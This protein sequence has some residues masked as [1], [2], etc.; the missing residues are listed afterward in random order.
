MRSL[1]HGSRRR[2]VL[3]VVSNTAQSQIMGLIA[4]QLTDC[5]LLAVNTTWWEYSRVSIEA[6][7]ERQ[8][9]PFRSLK[10]LSTD[11]VEKVLSEERPDIVVVGHDGVPGH[12]EFIDT[13]AGAGLP[14]L[15]IQDGILTKNTAQ[16]LKRP[17]PLGILRN[18]VVL[19][20]RFPA[21][22]ASERFSLRE[23]AA[24]TLYDLQHRLTRGEAVYG[25]GKTTKMAVFGR[26]TREILTA[27]G[28]HPSRIVVTGNPKFDRLHQV[29]RE[30]HG[31][32]IRERWGIPA[33]QALV[34]LLTQYFVESHIWTPEQR[35]EFVRSIAE[36]VASIPDTRLI[37]KIRHPR[38]S[39][40]EYR[41]IVTDMPNPP[42]VWGDAP[43]PELLSSVHLAIGVSS[44]AL[45][46]AMALERPVVIVDLREY[47]TG[48]SYFRGSG[49][50][51]VTEKAEIQPAIRAALQD[52]AVRRE[53][54]EQERRFVEDQAY[55]Q[56]GQAAARIADLIRSTAER[57][58]RLE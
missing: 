43:L 34:V 4:E 6:E 27:Q 35:A 40:E 31:M 9:I 32:A 20:L 14:T 2:I 55:L 42:I 50:I 5:D 18:L 28:V 19:P 1:Q 52:P 7:L 48:S 39:E 16:A 56:D 53:I 24:I 51:I 3:F 8:K 11:E 33:N 37:I 15:L 13:A 54:L 29:K 21:F 12:I 49:A 36:A 23:K 30:D 22:L 26:A 25:Q 58:V 45:L 47:G 46:E 41:K 44:T 10:R 17:D 38:E 57:R